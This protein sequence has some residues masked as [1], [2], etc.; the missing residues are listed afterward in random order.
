VAWVAGNSLDLVLRSQNGYKNARIGHF[1]TA[2]TEIYF[3]NTFNLRNKT[4]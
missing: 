4:K 2:T 1:L 3:Y